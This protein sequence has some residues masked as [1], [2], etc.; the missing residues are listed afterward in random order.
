LQGQDT[1]SSR[2][3]RYISKPYQPNELA[4]R[5]FPEI[6]FYASLFDILLSATFRMKWIAF[7]L[8]PNS[9]LFLPPYALQGAIL[10]FNITSA[11]DVFP[12]FYPTESEVT[13]SLTINL[14]T[15][16]LREWLGFSWLRAWFSGEHSLAW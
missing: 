6:L 14:N 12:I 13:T 10:K 11:V 16:M 8:P 9:G 1:S 15:A 7:N 5:N 4:L 3:S 2:R